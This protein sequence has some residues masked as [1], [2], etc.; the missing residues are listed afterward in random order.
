MSF[1]SGFGATFGVILAIVVVIVVIVVA[2]IL[3]ACIYIKKQANRFAPMMQI[4][5]GDKLIKERLVP[6]CKKFRKYLENLKEGESMRI[7]SRHPQYKHPVQSFFSEHCCPLC[8]E[9][10]PKL[11]G[12]NYPGTDSLYFTICDTYDEYTCVR[13]RF[14][15]Y[16]ESGRGV[17]QEE[18]ENLKNKNWWLVKTHRDMS[19]FYMIGTLEKTTL[20]IPNL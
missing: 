15:R 9:G 19:T 17:T 3:L 5:R 4:Y 12:F 6:A 2:I 1:S 20:P 11:V 18:Y 8:R 7:I 13:L 16:F 10:F 14:S